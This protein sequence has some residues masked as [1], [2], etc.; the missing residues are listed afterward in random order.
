MSGSVRSAL[1]ELT[2]SIPTAL[3]LRDILLLITILQTR[4]LSHEEVRKLAEG[5]TG[6]AKVWI[7]AF[8]VLASILLAMAERT[9]AQRE[10]GPGNKTFLWEWCS[11]KS[12]GL[13]PS[14]RDKEGS[15]AEVVHLTAALWIHCLQEHQQGLLR[16][17]L[18]NVATPSRSHVRTALLPELVILLHLL[19]LPV[20]LS[21][22]LETGLFPLV[23]FLTQGNAE[24]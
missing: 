8:L 10:D 18:W 14:V 12:A 17:V 1:H 21:P 5:R 13:L 9:L 19:K 20:P 4:K 24:G 23:S 2:C 16:S 7:L 6:R 22:H 15:R 3:C 11:L